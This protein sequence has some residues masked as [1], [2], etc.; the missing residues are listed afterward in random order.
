[1][2]IRAA[3]LADLDALVEMGGRFISRSVYH[4][5][6]RQNPERMRDLATHLIDS[7]DGELFVA[8]EHGRLIGMIAVVAY[9]DHITGDRTAGEV[10]WWVDE[11]HRGVG[12][13][14][15]RHAEQWARTQQATTFQM[16]APTRDVEQLYEHRGYQPIERIYR[17]ELR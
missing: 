6:L 12:L 5:K 14:L 10:A 8:E 3:T 7:Q 17:L 11:D 9:A 13:R 15:L 16:I 1:V 4:D 2:T